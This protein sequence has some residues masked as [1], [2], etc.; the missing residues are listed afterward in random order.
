MPGEAICLTELERISVR[1]R[2]ERFPATVKG[3]FIIRGEDPDPHQVVL[4]GS[5]VT[6]VDGRTVRPLSMGLATL[7]VAPHRDVFVPFEL[8]VSD[9][10]PGWYGFVCD[11]DVDGV[12]VSYP[13]DKRLVVAW[14]RATVRRGQIDIGRE[15]PLG[16]ATTVRIEQLE[17]TGDSIK[18]HLSAG[19]PTRLAVKLSADGDQ[20]EILRLEADET[21][22]RVKVTA[23]PLLRSHYSLTIA[24]KGRGARASVVVP[25]P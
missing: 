8:V 2:F 6:S 14:P 21:S 1:T 9:L 24:L 19:P 23:Y 13:G 18:L 5:R 11:V 15:L 10:D 3:A 20:L 22:G 16:S 7:D 12:P 25:L 17:C 4:R